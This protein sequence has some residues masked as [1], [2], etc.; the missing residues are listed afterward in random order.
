MHTGETFGRDDWVTFNANYPGFQAMQ[1]LDSVVSGDRVVGRAHV[2]GETDGMPKHFDV[3]LPTAGDGPDRAAH[4][5]VGRLR[6]GA[7]GG[8]TPAVGEELRR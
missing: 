7:T 1:L 5:G 6:R 2:I 8:H 3:E 4:R